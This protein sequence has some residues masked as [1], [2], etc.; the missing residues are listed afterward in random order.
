LNAFSQAYD[1]HSQYMTPS[2]LDNFTIN[3]RL[4]LTGIGAVLRSDDG[5]AKIVE[6]IPGGPADMDKRLKPNDRICA[7][8]QAEAEWVDVVDMKL[9]KV[10]DMIR[11]PKGTIVR[12]KVIPADASDSSVRSELKL[13]RDEIK[14]TEQEAKAKIVERTDAN[15]KLL[16]L[17]YIELPSFYVD[18]KKGPNAKSSTRDVAKL[19][20][21]LKAEKVDGLVMD[22]R[23]NSGGSLAEAISLTG[24]F[25]KEGPVVQVKDPHGRV[26]TQRDDDSSVA[27]NGPM[28]VLVSHLSASAA[29]IFSAALQDYGRALIVGAQSTFGKGTVQQIFELDRVVGFRKTAQESSGALKLTIQKFYRVSGGSTQARGVV[30]DIQLPSVLD[31]S[32]VG[33]TTLPHA[34][35]YDEVKRADYRSWGMV[36]EYLPE[37]RLRCAKRILQDAEFKYVREDTD[38]V[39]KRLEEKTISLNEAKREAEKKANLDRRDARKKERLARKA[40]PL[41]AT[42]ITLATLNGSTNVVSAVKHTIKKSAA[43]DDEDAEEADTGEPGEDPVF[44]ESFEILTDYVTLSSVMTARVGN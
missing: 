14:L 44:R 21:K 23:R 1:P 30:P 41:K 31:S 27:Y 10:V 3:M 15:G 32:P 39:K 17:G 43:S 36:G 25:I 35:P 26:I 34:L 20:E 38:L 4:S 33:E 18:T 37:L 29:E 40:E 19:L 13:T 9:N 2:S 11:G 8:A 42:D 16:R 12:L 7:V 5:Y 6:I 24:L 28:V 22:L